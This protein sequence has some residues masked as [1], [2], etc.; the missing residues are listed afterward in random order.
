MIAEFYR[1]DQA[2][3]VV[4]RAGWSR[5]GGATFESDD[6]G[7]ASILARVFRESPVV[8]DEPSL[9]AFGTKGVE[10]LTPASL[11]WFMAAARTRGAD[12]GL[13]VRFLPGE[14]SLVR[15]DPAGGYTTFFGLVERREGRA[16]A[17]RRATG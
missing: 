15:W 17:P 7:V 9:R 6:D 14:G 8:V 11:R 1:N 16:P 13:S 12:E 5:G 3:V 2:D 4:G 10:V